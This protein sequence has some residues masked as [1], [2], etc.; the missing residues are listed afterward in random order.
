[1]TRAQYRMLGRLVRGERL[2]LLRFRRV[3]T[4]AALERQGLVF[5][6]VMHGMSHAVMWQATDL[7]RRRHA[8]QKPRPEVDETIV[9]LPPE[10]PR[11]SSRARGPGIRRREIQA[12]PAA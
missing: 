2:T 8:E 5:A 4:M 7:G 9:R 1:M 10:P 11:R 3:G 12:Q 6:V